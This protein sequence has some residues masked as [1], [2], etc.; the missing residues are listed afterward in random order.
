VRDFTLFAPNDK[1]V[2]A[3]YRSGALNYPYLFARNKTTL[4][5]I[6]AYHAVP[7]AQHVG[8][9]KQTLNMKTLL[10]EVRGVVLR[11]C[12]RARAQ[13]HASRT[14]RARHHGLQTPAAA[15]QRLTPACALVVCWMTVTQTGH[16]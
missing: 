7:Q 4:D 3:A 9:S 15:A 14:R 6:V 16:R 1:A 5:G 2:M 10:T 8:P 13:A 12:A 11:A